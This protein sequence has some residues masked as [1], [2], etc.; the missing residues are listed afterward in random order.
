MKLQRGDIVDVALN[1]GAFVYR[2]VVRSATKRH[3]VH[4][5]TRKSGHTYRPNCVASK[6]SLVER[7]GR[8][9][10]AELF[11]MAQAFA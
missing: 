11:K 7:R 2:G 3:G 4:V 1:D 5:I 9:R 10:F 8:K 6:L